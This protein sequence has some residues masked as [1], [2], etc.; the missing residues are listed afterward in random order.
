MVRPFKSRG[1]A[2]RKLAE[3]LGKYREAEPV[4]LALPRGGVP[5]GYEVARSLSAPLDILLVRKISVPMAPELAAGAVVDGAHPQ[6]VLNDEIVRQYN[7][8]QSYI[9]DRVKQQL[10]EIERRRKLYRPG[11]APIPLE[12]RTIIVVDDGIATGATVRAALKGL[13]GAGAE[14]IVLAVPIAPA[15]VLDTLAGEADEVVCLETPSPFYA[16]GEYYVDFRQI[17]DDLVVA[18]LS[19]A[20]AA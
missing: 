9:Q 13:K 2:G 5:V 15:D 17:S 8:P 3:S 7:I 14:K 10:T 16:V 6:V 11:H 19:Q 12:G 20:C 4:I 18:Y 1:D